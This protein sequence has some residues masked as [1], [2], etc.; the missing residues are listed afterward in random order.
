MIRKRIAVRPPVVESEKITVN[1]GYVDLGQIDL[2]VND[3]FYSNRTDLIRTAIRNQLERHRDATEKSIIKRRVE[4]GLARYTR[5]HLEAVKAAGEML[6]I[7]MLGLV[8]VENDVPVRLATETISSVQ[9]LG[10]FHASSAVKIALRD[11]IR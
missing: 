9:V 1:L 10:A 2:L 3:G 5:A 6:D 4:V 8:V 11:R 7:R